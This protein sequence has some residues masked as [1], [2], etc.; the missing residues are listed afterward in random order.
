MK[1]LMEALETIRSLTVTKLGEDMVL[2]TSNEVED[3]CCN[4]I[5]IQLS[6]GSKY[7]IT[8]DDRKVTIFESK[9]VGREVEADIEVEE[10]ILFRIIDEYPDGMF[11][12]PEIARNY[13]LDS[14]KVNRV[15]E[16]LFKAGYNAKRVIKQ[17]SNTNND[18]TILFMFDDAALISDAFSSL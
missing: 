6:S 15:L 5:G 8:I 13:Q 7:A 1:E 9:L 14:V 10:S 2:V 17:L 3:R 16:V 12:L 18:A 4:T 11:L